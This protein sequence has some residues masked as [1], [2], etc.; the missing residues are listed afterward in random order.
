MNL[1]LYHY[2]G[3]KWECTIDIEIVEKSNSVT[4]CVLFKVDYPLIALMITRI[5]G[6]S[7]L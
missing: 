4:Y 6:L 2:V 7:P 3:R 5:P 1:I